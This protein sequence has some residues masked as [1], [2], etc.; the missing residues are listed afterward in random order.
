MINVLY[1]I[2]ESEVGGAALSLLNMLEAN[3]GKLNP[4]IVI[5][6]SGSLEE[7]IS[8]LQ[9]KYCI[10]PF[11]TD[12]KV[13]GEHT[14]AQRDRVFTNNYQAAA[15][16]QKIIKEMNIQLIHTNSSISNVGAIAAL[17]AGIPHVWHIRELLEEDFNCEFVDKKLKMDLLGC[18]D[19][20]IS[21][22]HC[23][24]EAF[25]QKYDIDS[26]CIYNGVSTSRFLCRDLT[27]KNNNYFMIAGLIFPNKGQLDVV[28]A[29]N[30]LVKKGIDVQLYIAG[31]TNGY[32]Y[33][34][35][36]EKY[37]E[38]N[39]LQYNVHILE[40]QK[41]LRPL[42][43]KCQFSVTASKMEAL[44]RVTIES[45]LAGCV[46]IGADTG[47]T[48]EIIG[49]DRT[50]GYLYEQGNHEDLAD[51]MQYAMEHGEQNRSIQRRAQSYAERQFNEVSYIEKI[52]KVYENVICAYKDTDI[53]GK[54]CVLRKLEERYMA[55]K[56]LQDDKQS[57]DTENEEKQIKIIKMKELM[58]DNLQGICSIEEALIYRKIE[59]IAIYGMGYFG[60]HLYDA[61]E[62][63]RVRIKYVMDRAL[64]D[65]SEIIN[66]VNLSDELP[67]VD[68]VIVTVLGNTKEIIDLLKGKSVDKIIT[69]EEVLSW[70]ATKGEEDIII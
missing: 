5:S 22:S 56:R 39:D 11:E 46:V 69:L 4:V 32:Q 49:C 6:A 70:S 45:M 54:V 2:N 30:I 13:I 40:F 31:A 12:N 42:R 67:K 25:K 3:K 26:V 21:I 44:G 1:I 51:I 68:A 15:T 8:Q 48:A 43:E 63:G 66:V 9:I 60:C 10:V 58:M 20:V 16:V 29:V 55:S 65:V 14:D 47:G 64:K 17:M 24:R 36:L 23:V 41:D 62:N 34:W 57:D 28:K 35:I 7:R 18:A 61:L 52:M 53:N 33:K 19:A 27:T 59:T 37:I 50:K 38:K